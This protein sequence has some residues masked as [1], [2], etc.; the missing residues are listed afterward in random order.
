MA[1][2]EETKEEWA[3][4]QRRAEDLKLQN[5][6]DQALQGSRSIEELCGKVLDVLQSQKA[7]GLQAAAGVL[8]A[9]DGGGVR[10]L[11]SR[12]SDE[13]ALEQDEAAFHA[14]LSS[15]GAIDASS[16]RNT[17]E[18]R[19]LLPLRS[20]GTVIAALCFGVETSD[21][22]LERWPAVLKA[23]GPS[24]GAT[25]ERLRSDE[26]IRNINQDLEIARDAAM[27]ASRAKSAF[28]A[29]MSHE[30]RT[31]LNAIIGYS[32]MLVDELKEMGSDALVGDAGKI[33][34]SGKRLLGIVNDLLDLN[35]IE[36]GKMELVVEAVPV[37]A[38][39]SDV[40][41]LAK[42]L[43]PRERTAWSST[44]RPTRGT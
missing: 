30:L 12:G 9:E 34:A 41:L 26:R 4:L 28:L 17:S 6:I 32:E 31:P 13:A 43:L 22:W 25:I 38:V 16:L 44:S 18:T 3:R 33:R 2:L 36:A 42:P 14:M 37:S 39:M 23:L 8:L 20:G 5:Q 10:R 35:K 40:A 27:E 19:H 24:I 11:A 15:T 7:L 29:N 1:E 21:A